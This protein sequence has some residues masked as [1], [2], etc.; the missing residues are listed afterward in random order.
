MQK[1]TRSQNIGMCT[2]RC[3]LI[4]EGHKMINYQEIM[5]LKAQSISGRSIALSYDLHLEIKQE[6]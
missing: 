6:S 5:R 3:K 2:D 4:Y 1:N